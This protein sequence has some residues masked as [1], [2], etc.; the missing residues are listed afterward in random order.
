MLNRLVKWKVAREGRPDSI[1]RGADP[2]RVEIIGNQVGLGASAKSVVS[3]GVKGR[4]SSLHGPVLEA[5]LLGT[6][7][8]AYIRTSYLAAD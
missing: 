6:F 2:R 3:P 4:T 5:Q 8:S 7:T 1:E